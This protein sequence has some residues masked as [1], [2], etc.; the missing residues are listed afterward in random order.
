MTDGKTGG[1]AS[2][3]RNLNFSLDEDFFEGLIELS[4]TFTVMRERERE[5]RNLFQ[6][7]KYKMNLCFTC[8]TSSGGSS[9]SEGCKFQ[10]RTRYFWQLLCCL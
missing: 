2:A 1:G 10:N 5:T 6:W 3:S 9:V 8:S 7:W 4:Y